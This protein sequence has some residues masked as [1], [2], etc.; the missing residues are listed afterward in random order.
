MCKH[1]KSLPYDYLIEISC[2]ETLRIPLQEIGQDCFELDMIVNLRKKVKMSRE[3][4]TWS[5]FSYE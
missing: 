3:V 1:F 4:Y 2:L 5:H